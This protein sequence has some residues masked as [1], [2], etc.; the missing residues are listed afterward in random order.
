MR[1]GERA[2]HCCRYMGTRD[3]K[4]KSRALC[5]A[6]AMFLGALGVDTLCLH[7]VTVSVLRQRGFLVLFPA[8]LL[9]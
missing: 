6:A 1:D 8:S 7:P 9:R 5:A 3:W 2:H 4:Q